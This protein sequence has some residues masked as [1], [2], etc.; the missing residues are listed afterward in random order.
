MSTTVEFLGPQIEEPEL[1]VVEGVDWEKCQDIIHAV[2]FQGFV[3]PQF[4]GFT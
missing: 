3:P 4:Q 2:G 1:E